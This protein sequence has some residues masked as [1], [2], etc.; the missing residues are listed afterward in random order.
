MTQRVAGPTQAFSYNDIPPH[1]LAL[2]DEYATPP[3]G[4]IPC[5]PRKRA[6]INKRAHVPKKAILQI[7]P[8]NAPVEQIL[9]T[10]AIGYR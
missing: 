7:L 8:L 5:T 4:H 1:L 6:K 2:P 10:S 9:A 3:T